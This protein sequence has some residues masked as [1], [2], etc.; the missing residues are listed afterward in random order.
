MA[1]SPDLLRFHHHPPHPNSLPIPNS[2]SPKTSHSTPP[3]PPASAYSARRQ[4]PRGKK[5]QSS[6]T[7][8]ASPALVISV[9]YRL[10]PEH[11]LPAAYD[12]AVEA[13]LWVRD[14]ALGIG[15]NGCDEWLTELADFS[16]VYLMGSS[17]GGN[18]VY[19][20]GLR[21][22][23]MDLD[24]I[25]IVGLIMN[26]PFFGGV[27]RTETEL[28]LVNDRIVPLTANDLMWSLALP[29]GC[30][31]DHE[32]CD[33]LRDQDKSYNEKITRLPK[34][35]IKGHGG[36]PL[37]DRQKEFAKMLEARGVHVT[38]KFGDDGYHGVEIFDTKKAQ[39]LYDDIKRF[40]WCFDEKK[41]TL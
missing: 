35:L 31:R 40:I 3:P 26:Q 30:E 18:I 16:K 2:L 4:P 5:S 19:N 8:T 17:S 23:D 24:P 41:S 27:K 20:A 22:L 10:A 28:R 12:D 29:E 13:I 1:H 7:S 37:V 36:D 11:R 25:K 38:R 39:V 6:S 14:Q 32:Y 21:A 33:P 9:E 34:C 15:I